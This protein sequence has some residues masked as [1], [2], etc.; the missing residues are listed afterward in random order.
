[1]AE[2]SPSGSGDAPRPS[3]PAP[4]GMLR[5]RGGVGGLSFQFEE[6]LAGAAA[7]DGAVSQLYALEAEADS[8]RRSLFG[9]QPDAYRSG[10][11]AIIAVGEAGRD[12]GRVR[13]ELENIA[14]QVRASHR[15]YEFTEARNALLLRMGLSGPEYGSAEGAFQLPGLRDQ[16]EQ[17]VAL[18]PHGLALLLGVP[19]PLA[20]AL[21]AS[22][23]VAGGPGDLR[24]TIRE[25]TAMPG[26]GFLK[27]RPVSVIR[28]ESGTAEVDL[29]A[30]GLL[31]QA[32]A[33]GRTSGDI[34]VIQTDVGDS[35]AWVVVLP[36]TQL[37]GLPAGTN[38]FDTA[39]IAE[40]LGYD[41][42]ETGLAIRQA[43]RDAGAAAGEQ[44]AAVGYSQGGIHAMNLSSDEAFLAEFDLKFV[45]TAGSPVGGITPGPGISSLHLEHQHDWVPGSDGTPNP[46]TRDRV[47][48]T[49]TNDL[50]LP[51]GQDFGLG[52]GHRLENYVEGAEAIS[53][54]RDPSLQASAA[55]LAAVVGSGGTA[56]VTRF[57]LRR[58]ASPAG[59]ATA[60]GPEPRVRHPDASRGARRLRG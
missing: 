53:G 38:P 30:A 26:L 58:E 27:P 47:T 3:A 20:E 9:Y 14:A 18:V 4:D 29:S 60:T 42:R 23:A 1:M 17:R 2:P 34:E 25:L 13:A 21:K 57:S 31:R 10:S 15:E 28:S 41:S 55:A 32:E 22:G 5:I 37:D 46:D 59:P 51:P 11:N 12:I 8:V 7:L 49:L 48:V 35:R 36:G 6:L 56:S 40:A 52:P 43:L 44:V 33:V 50:V 54:S 45:L 19:L 16:V 24:R 39:G